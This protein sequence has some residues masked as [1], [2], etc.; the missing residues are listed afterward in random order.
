MDAPQKLPTEPNIGPLRPLPIAWDAGKLVR[1]AVQ[2]ARRDPS[3][4][5]ADKALAEACRASANLWEAEI[6]RITGA[7]TTTRKR[8]A[9]W[10]FPQDG[11]E[12]STQA[13][14]A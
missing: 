13:N 6:R 3:W 9:P 2:S 5:N 10:D 14:R 7:H 4:D 1:A 12:T 8:P 11:V